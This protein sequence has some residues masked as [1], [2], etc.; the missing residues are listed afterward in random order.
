MKSC[1]FFALF[2]T[3][4]SGYINDFAINVTFPGYNATRAFIIDTIETDEFVWQAKG[5]ARFAG[6][7]YTFD[8]EKSRTYRAGDYLF[9]SGFQDGKTYCR[10]SGVMSQDNMSLLPYKNHY[11]YFGLVRNST[12]AGNA[13]HRTTAFNGKL[14]A[15]R[16]SFVKNRNNRKTVGDFLVRSFRY[17]QMCLH[18]S[19]TDD[20]KIKQTVVAVGARVAED[21]LKGSYYYNQDNYWRVPATTFKIGD[22]EFNV[23]QRYNMATFH[24]SSPK[25]RLPLIYFDRVVSAVGAVNETGKYIVDCDKRVEL[26]IGLNGKRFKIQFEALLRRDKPD[27]KKCELLLERND[28][29]YRNSFVLGVPFFVNNGVCFGGSTATFYDATY[30]E[31]RPVFPDTWGAYVSVRNE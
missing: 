5:F 25:I 1:Y 17:P 16:L 3:L 24:T 9:S 6:E 31:K 8:E 2:I 10:L 23:T 11:A 21:R 19:V 13:M 18:Q 27:D 7:D 22:A 30:D 29:I 4:S 26:E 14:R 12:C 20:L 15:G 28:D